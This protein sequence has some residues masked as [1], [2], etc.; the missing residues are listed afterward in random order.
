[1][2][3]NTKDTWTA[4]IIE[5]IQ[6]E[7]KKLGITDDSTRD[8]IT[9]KIL[10]GAK[11][12][13]AQNGAVDAQSPVFDFSGKAERFLLLMAKLDVNT[14]T[15]E[16]YIQKIKNGRDLFSQNPETSKKN[17]VEAVRDLQKAGFETTLQ[18]YFD[19]AL[20]RVPLLQAR[21]TTVVNRLIGVIEGLKEKK[22]VITPPQYWKAVKKT[23]ALLT[24]RSDKVLTNIDILIQMMADGLMGDKLQ[25]ASPQERVEEMLQRSNYLTASFEKLYLCRFYNEFSGA[26]NK[27]SLRKPLSFLKQKLLDALPMADISSEKND[28]RVVLEIVDTMDRERA[29][30]AQNPDKNDPIHHYDSRLGHL[31]WLAIESKQNAAA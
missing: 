26:R 22:I 20:S 14:P 2:A 8:K 25:Q 5:R 4:E 10:S 18:E 17:L 15:L 12:M 16:E 6:Q 27:N 30:R 11:W 1:M 21:S 9:A 28:V 23:S 13:N 31:A 19:I 7:L 3:K 24:L 29:R